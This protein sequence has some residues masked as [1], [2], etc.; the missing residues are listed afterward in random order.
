MPD[1]IVVGSLADARRLLPLF[2][3]DSASADISG[4]VFNG[5]TKYDRNVKITGDL[6]KSWQIKKGGLEIIFHLRKG[7]KW[8]DGRDF[9]SADVLFTYKTVT[10][11]KVPTP[12]SSNYGPVEKVEAPDPYT[13]KVY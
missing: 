12:Y 2:A 6:A 9:T 13:V 8:Q 3:A 4:L 11:P 7:V 1:T 10:D 5:L